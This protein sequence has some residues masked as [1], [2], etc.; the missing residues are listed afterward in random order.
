M[1][2]LTSPVNTLT[3]DF[4]WFLFGFASGSAPIYYLNAGP[5]LRHT[6]TSH[7]NPPE[8]GLICPI[9]R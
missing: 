1:I 8:Q 4:S 6:W 5:Y 9:D 7:P 3:A 2:Y